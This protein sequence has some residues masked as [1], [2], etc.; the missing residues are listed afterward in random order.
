MK[1]GDFK[2]RLATAI[3]LTSL[4]MIVEVAGGVISGSLSLL[5]D[6]GHM[7]RDV[8]A[9]VVSLSALNIAERLPTKTKTFGFHR[10]EI[11]AS[12]VNGLVLM[13]VGLWILW[14]AYHRFRNPAPVQSITMLWVAVLGLVVN[15]YIAVRLH[16]SQDLNIKSAFVHVVTDAVVS[17]GVIIAALLITWTG[18]SVFDPG[19]STAISLVVIASAAFL[20]RDSVRVLLE[21]APDDVDFDRMMEDMLQVEGVTGVHSVHL[22]SLCS[23]MKVIDAHVVT[24]ATDLIAVEGIKANLKQ[25]LERYGIKHATLEFECESGALHETVERIEH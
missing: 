19:V 12:F 2:R 4:F 20:I 11:F 18:N 9:L 25:R 7:L 24:R 8:L 23:N 13:G 22:W 5:G 3:L 21:F 10:V 17:V 6:A 14:E 1:E 16:G 15:G